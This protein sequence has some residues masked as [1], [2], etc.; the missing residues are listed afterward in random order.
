MH[1]TYVDVSAS[2]DG[3]IV[4]SSSPLLEKPTTNQ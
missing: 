4:T 2:M 1:T 3:D